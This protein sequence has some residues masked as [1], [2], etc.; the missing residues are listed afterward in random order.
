MEITGI[1]HDIL[2]LSVIDRKK[3]PDVTVLLCPELTKYCP[4]LSICEPLVTSLMLIRTHLTY[5]AN[6]KILCF[7]KQKSHSFESV[8]KACAS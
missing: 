3:N 6:A 1:P 7:M 4:V 2:F 8:R 5:I